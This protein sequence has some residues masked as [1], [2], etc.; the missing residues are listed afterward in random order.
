[1]QYATHIATRAYAHMCT[2]ALHLFTTNSDSVLTAAVVKLQ[3]VYDPHHARLYLERNRPHTF[4]SFDYTCP[5]LLSD[6]VS[7]GLAPTNKRI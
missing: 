4:G 5:R 2:P 3:R 6:T 1:M 7:C